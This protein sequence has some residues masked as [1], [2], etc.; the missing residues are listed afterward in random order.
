MK[1]RTFL[2]AASAT[3]LSACSNTDPFGGGSESGQTDTIRIGSANFPESEIIAEIYA[4][5]LEA[6][7]IKVER[8]MQI[9]AR[10]VYIA[11]LKD[12]SVDLVPDYTGNLLQYFQPETTAR[13]A[14]DVA[15]SLKKFT[16]KGM[17]TLIP[18]DAENKDAYHVT[19]E[20]A[21][22]HGVKSLADLA[23]LGSFK[24]GGNPELAGRP[25]GPKGLTSVYEI[26]EGTITFVPISD[27]GGPLTLKALL[28]GEVDVADIYSTTPSISENSLVTLAD[29]KNLIVAQNVVA[30]L[31]DRVTNPKV[32]QA[33]NS[34]S[35]K[36][37]TG[38]LVEL[39][40]ENQG[41]SKVSPRDAAA[42][43]LAKKGR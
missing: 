6:A 33:L 3:M 29:P 17:S 31:S 8:R 22:K 18:A 32:S 19:A 28:D 38:D 39:N 20:F 34:V 16:P 37:T 35:T 24:L 13:S 25:Y 15:E 2:M 7:G 40:R 21:A 12:G 11:A 1:R 43:W 26:A 30:L 4:Q 36:L 9:G 27:S 14:D 42:N 41:S 5:S 23:K 10:D